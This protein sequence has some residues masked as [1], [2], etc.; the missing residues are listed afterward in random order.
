MTPVISQTPGMMRPLAL[1]RPEPYRRTTVEIASDT[2]PHEA[3]YH[4]WPRADGPVAVIVES[5][6]GNYRPLPH[7]IRHSPAGFNCGYDGNGPRDLALSL[8]ADALG[9]LIPGCT[10]PAIRPGDTQ[11]PCPSNAPAIPVMDPATPEDAHHCDATLAPLP[12]L[13][14]AIQIVAHLPQEKTWSL[15][16]RDILRWVADSYPRGNYILGS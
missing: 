6:I 15:C 2:N 12:Y 10:G 11:A 5:P 3:V 1:R 4:G 8:L 9:D 16:R 13:H 7:L 14:F